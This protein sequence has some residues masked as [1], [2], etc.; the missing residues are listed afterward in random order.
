MCFQ[1]AGSWGRAFCLAQTWRGRGLRRLDE[2]YLAGLHTLRFHFLETLW[3]KV[4]FPTLATLELINKIQNHSPLIRWVG[5]GGESERNM[6]ERWGWDDIWGLINLHL[7]GEGK[8]LHFPAELSWIMTLTIAVYR[9]QLHQKNDSTATQIIPQKKPQTRTRRITKTVC[10][11][12]FSFFL[13]R[14]FKT[15]MSPHYW[16]HSEFMTHFSVPWAK[17]E[18][19][20]LRHKSISPHQPP[21]D[22]VSIDFTKPHQQTNQSLCTLL[23]KI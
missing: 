7:K 8:H 10:V 4:P 17:S 15:F 3:S 6:W 23:L 1:V 18:V 12:A 5:E 11:D 20:I 19:L 14:C 21:Q 9:K 2:S 13:I 22:L 16:S